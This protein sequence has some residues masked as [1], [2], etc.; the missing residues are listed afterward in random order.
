MLYT[1]E[2]ILAIVKAFGDL[3][4]SQVGSISGTYE[5]DLTPYQQA[6]LALDFKEFKDNQLQNT[7][8]ATA[9]N[10]DVDLLLGIN[11]KGIGDKLSETNHGTIYLNG[12]RI[13]FNAK[14]DFAMMFGATGVA[15]GSLNQVNIDAGRSI[16]LFAHD[17]LFLGLPNKGIRV[18]QTTSPPPPGT[19]KGDPTPDQ[20]YEP[21]VL[22]IKLA[23]LLEDILIFLKKADMV[24]GVS[25]VRFQP[26][27]MAEFGLLANR[28]PEMLSSYAYLDGYSHESVNMKNLETL[29]A[30]QKKAKNYVPPEQLKGV[31]NGTGVQQ[32]GG[33]D[34]TPVANNVVPTATPYVTLAGGH[35]A[36]WPNGIN[37]HTNK[38]DP[39]ISPG[40][41]DSLHAFT[42]D[43]RDYK[44]VMRSMDIQV[45]K[46]LK[47][48]KDQHGKPADVVGMHVVIDPNA[49]TKQVQWEV[50]IQE[51]KNGIH[52]SSFTSRG[53]AGSTVEDV[54]YRS[55]KQIDEHPANK[56]GRNFKK[57]S[58]YLLN[59]KS[60]K[61]NQIFAIYS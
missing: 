21:L 4:D 41:G 46:A 17:R 57:V 20:D 61:I 59:T 50:L 53:G 25:P 6:V 35:G 1:Y 44:H 36:Y 60:L 32:T 56:T 37:P 12:E 43:M 7:I 22:G 8:T 39:R 23:N 51:S 40:N 54:V 19:S 42:S 13:I 47:F 14:D 45:N 58:T 38:P 2:S 11:T 55:N 33:S 31:A 52:Y 3:G 49:Q 30:A 26:T 10:P 15:L 18:T 34:Y 9:A 5:I 16:T 29:K 24:S 48:F 28:I 27:T